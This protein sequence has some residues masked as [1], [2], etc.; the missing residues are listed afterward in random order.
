[1]EKNYPNSFVTANLYCKL[2]ARLAT[3]TAK[4]IRPLT[5]IF[6]L[7]FIFNFSFAQA[8]A[9]DLCASAVTL[10]PKTA[11]NTTAPA[12]QAASTLFNATNTG[13]PSNIY[14]TTYDVWYRFTTPA[15]GA[16]TINIALSG[17]GSAITNNNTL[18]EVF[19]ANTCA[20]ISAN[21]SLGTATRQQGLSIINVAHY[22]TYYFRVFTIANPTSTPSSNWNFSVCV[23]YTAAPGNDDCAGAIALTPG[24]TNTTGTLKNA[25]NS[26][27]AVS[28]T[29]AG[30]VDDD[31]WYSF[32]ANNA[33]ANI[34]AGSE[35]TLTPAVTFVEV[36]SGT[37]GTLT[38]IGCG[39]E[40]VYVTG[41]SS[42]TTYYVRVYTASAFGTP[43]AGPTPNADFSI[44][45]SSPSTSNV[46]AGRM[47]EVYQQSILSTPN[48]LADPWEI[49]YGSDGFLWITESKGYRLFRMNPAT[50]ARTTV[51]DLSRGSTFFSAAGDRAFNIQFDHAIQ[52]AQ[53]GFAGMALHPKFLDATSPQNYVYVSYVHSYGGG[54]AP[55]G[56]FFSNRLV[57][58]TYNVTT[59]LLESPV[60]L[61]DTLPG[62]NDHNSQRIIIAPVSGT[63]YLFYASG[64][65]G[66]GQFGNRLRPIKV[67]HINSYEGKILRF[68][69]E[70]DGDAGLNAWIPNDNPFNATLGVQ[71]AV[72]V[73]G[74]RNNQGFA[75]DTSLNR[76]Y[77]SS[78]GPYSDDEI[79]IIESARNYGHPLVAGYAADDNYNGITVGTR[80]N[81]GGIPA[82]SAPLITDESDNAAA[83]GA[84]YKDP[85]FSAYPG[86]AGQVNAIWNYTTPTPVPGN[87]TWPSEG[88]SGLDIY[89]HTIIPGWKNSLVAAGLK[90][91]RFIRLK[92]NATGDAVV[93]T[94]GADTV[95]YL[96]STNRYRDLAIA[97]NG[98][99]IYVVMDKNS[100]T[101]GPTTG[102]SLV[103]A[104]A[105]CIQKYSFLGYAD[106]AGKSSIPTAIDVT[107]GTAN[108][109]ANG[110]PVTIDN[111]NN[112]YWVPITGPDGNIMA[113]IFANGQ[114]LGTVISTFYKN[115]GAIRVKGSVRYL[116]RNIT[117]TPQ[118]QPTSAVKIRLY[119]S[120]AE[121]DALDADGLSGV[122]AIGDVKILKNGDACGSTIGTSTTLISPAFSEAH[123][124]NG[125]M[126]QG[127]TNSFSTFYFA[128]ANVTL[129][130]N[131]I[132]FTG[133][134]K[135]GST[136]LKWETEN[137]ANTDYFVVERSAFNGDYK[138]IGTLQAKGSI[139]ARALYNFTDGE[140]GSLGATVLYYRLRIVDKDGKIS[141]SQVVVITI[142]D[143]VTSLSVYP[144]PAK[145]EAT[146]FITSDVEQQLN[147]QLIDN[148]GRVLLTKQAMVNKGNNSIA[149]D[150]RTLPAGTYFIKVT[151][152]TVQAIQKLQKQ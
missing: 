96:Q 1:M 26:G 79:N 124:A 86:S 113:E 151:G 90:W 9:N 82:S 136:L 48:I 59:G 46:T 108:S 107:A 15:S 28:S 34:I 2:C 78:H 145:E 85:L 121:Y 65:V 148:A 131:L 115:S 119:F 66:A 138:S 92:L 123:G 68:N 35:F 29:C 36:F 62:S 111:N 147:W 51:L 130:L 83:I 117:I 61:C 112:N 37:C 64:D 97:P 72:W 128:S 56:I 84:S 69:I 73:T 58:F 38:S 141:Y 55:T 88:W 122:N 75:Y 47:N 91:G 80:L 98:K 149:I 8:P 87:N 135:N 10:T 16:S 74:I 39:R 150:I 76:L 110:T 106:A 109:C 81:D 99:D 67:Q 60:S 32:V 12:S 5:A 42:G 103:P 53:G 114:N 33:A 57:R 125:Y 6:F 102:S 133:T 70:K 27:V 89:K 94:A 45:V 18:I 21:N 4:K 95:T 25:T 40:S 134:Y 93:P 139:D 41:L 152:K 129:P 17:A 105:G 100:A 143:V 19:N 24:T 71:S 50:G 43:I 52:G 142:A 44:A 132:T 13:S 127:S 22:A 137:E 146:L 7:Q 49:T 144:N 30:T 77:G 140:A 54:A 14:G 23:S 63:N 20:A 104:C 126:L 31:V 118:N 3:G 11:C 116:D 101:S 120:K